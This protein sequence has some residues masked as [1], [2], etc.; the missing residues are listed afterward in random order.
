[1]VLEETKYKIVALRET[2]WLVVKF[3]KKLLQ[4]GTTT[5]YNAHNYLGL[6]IL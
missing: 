2:W 1:M 4:W 6:I 5:N 3:K